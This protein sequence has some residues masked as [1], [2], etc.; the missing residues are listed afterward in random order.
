MAAAPVEFLGVVLDGWPVGTVLTP[1]HDPERQAAV[2]FAEVPIAGGKATRRVTTITHLALMLYNP[3]K[4]PRA[5]MY[6]EERFV[7][8]D[9][10]EDYFVYGGK[11]PLAAQSRTGPLLPISEAPVPMNPL[12]GAQPPVELLRF[13]NMFDEEDR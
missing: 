1:R 4:A 12:G 7:R 11:E 3:S 8:L 2:L 6:D 5:I 13:A 9:Q 10:G